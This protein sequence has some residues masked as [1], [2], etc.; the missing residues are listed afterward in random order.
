[1]ETKNK[2]KPIKSEQLKYLVSDVR[3]ICNHYITEN[4]L[5]VHAFAKQCAVHPNQM[6]MFLNNERGLNL[7]TVQKIGDLINK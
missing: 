1:M 2:I 6:Y 5:S 3:A 7:P 4:N